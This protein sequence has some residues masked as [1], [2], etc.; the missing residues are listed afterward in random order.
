MLNNICSACTTHCQH[1]SGNEVCEF[2]IGLAQKTGKPSLL[3]NSAAS[4]NVGC[5]KTTLNSVKNDTNVQRFPLSRFIPTLELH[6]KKNLY[7]MKY[8]EVTQ[9]L[10]SKH[11]LQPLGVGG[12]KIVSRLSWSHF[13]NI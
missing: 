2:P 3:G 7:E 5:V 13:I 4:K 12:G 10:G 1:I 6:G 11:F 8:H 9:I